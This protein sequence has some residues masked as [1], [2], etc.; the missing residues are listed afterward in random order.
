MAGP[1]H[2][3]HRPITSRRHR[4]I[5]GSA[6]TRSQGN[7]PFAQRWSRNIVLNLSTAAAGYRDGRSVT[8]PIGAVAGPPRCHR[9][10]SGANESFPSA[11]DARPTDPANPG[12]ATKMRGTVIWG[13][14]SE[15]DLTEVSRP[16]GCDLRR[17]ATNAAGGG[18]TDTG[19]RSGTIPVR[20]AERIALRSLSISRNDRDE[21][22]G[23]G[24]PIAPAP[25][26]RPRP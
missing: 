6:G 17:F 26:S 15:G 13:G 8:A 12:C 3:G 19:R 10:H 20:P 1:R 7:G 2:W 9:S 21:G 24:F 16:D 18:V 5:V 4:P 25:R 14:P 22:D 23:P 11:D